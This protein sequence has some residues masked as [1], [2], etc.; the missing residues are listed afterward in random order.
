MFKSTRARGRAARRLRLGF[1]LAAASFAGL[2]AAGTAPA[3][4]SQPP[5]G[6]HVTPCL[7]IASAGGDTYVF[8]AWESNAS[9]KLH[10]IDLT[11]WSKGRPTAVRSTGRCV[12]PVGP[13]HYSATVLYFNLTCSLHPAGREIQV[14]FNDRR[15]LEKHGSTAEYLQ[16]GVDE[17]YAVQQAAAVAGCPLK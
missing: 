9:P 5:A 12:A 15:G 17:A 11:L 10:S 7:L 4:E 6:C 16:G 13:E 1:A 8:T 3:A 14:C 2:F